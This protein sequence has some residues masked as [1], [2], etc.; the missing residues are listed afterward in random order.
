MKSE[1]DLFES[2]PTQTSLDRA[3]WYEYPPTASLADQGPLEFYVSGSGEDYIDLLYTVLYLRVRVVSTDGAV[4]PENTVVGPVNAFLHT[5]FNQ[6]EVT[7]NGKTVGHPNTM[8]PYRAI[9]E[10]LMNYGPEAG[11]GSLQSEL[12]YKDTSGYMDA[13]NPLTSNYSE[14]VHGFHSRQPNLAGV[15]RLQVTPAANDQPA[16]V[17][18]PIQC[19][20]QGLHL[21]WQMTRGSQVLELMGPIHSDIFQQEK[22]LPNNVDLTLKLHRSKP[23]FCLM[24]SANAPRNFKVEIQDATLF[25]R[26]VNVADHV[27]LAQQQ[28]LLSTNAIYPLNHVVMKSYSIPAGNFVGPQDN[29]FLGQL[30]QEMV[31]AFV[32]N[33]AANGN[34]A[35]NPFNFKHM[36]I[37]HMVVKY[38]G[39]Q[40]PAKPLSLH[41]DDALKSGGQY[42][43]IYHQF[44][45]HTGKLFKDKGCMIERHDFPRGYA[46]FAFDFRPD[47]GCRGHYSLQK[48]GAVQVE[49][50][51]REQLAQT[52]T[53]IV[54]AAFDSYIELTHA[55]EVIVPS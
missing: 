2:P 44:C 28:A 26:K 53:M 17:V 30:P 14:R 1:L 20:N 10:K 11:K 19:G 4:L 48:T 25:V 27:F 33:D 5:L 34:F 21:R 55:R 35:K 54:Y 3:D 15:E 45:A 22:F 47:F 9:I 42:A 37:S 18:L 32:D 16:A 13:A 12:F 23:E 31:L 41:F 46:L 50:Q 43:R 7:I 40:V 39:T 8:Y 52:I 51:F 38:G 24:S 36:N 49:I 29:I 6:V